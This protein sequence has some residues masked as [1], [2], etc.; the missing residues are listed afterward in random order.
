MKRIYY[1]E[2]K[3]HCHSEAYSS[4]AWAARGEFA[5]TKQ[6]ATPYTSLLKGLRKK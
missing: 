1:D 5:A 2:E 3:T 6:N 4:H